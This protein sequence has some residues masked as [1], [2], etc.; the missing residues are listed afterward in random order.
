MEPRDDARQTAADRPDGGPGDVAEL[1][2]LVEAGVLIP[3][4]RR[5]AEVLAARPPL[6]IENASATI[7]AIDE[8]RVERA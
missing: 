4:T 6:K 7:S 2:H 5:L 8:Q 1:P 3:A